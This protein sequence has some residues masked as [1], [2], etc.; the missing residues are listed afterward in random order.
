LVSADFQDR[1]SKGAKLEDLK[2]QGVLRHEK[3]IKM[4]QGVEME[5]L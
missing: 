2:V 1:N 5:E 3:N 4:Y